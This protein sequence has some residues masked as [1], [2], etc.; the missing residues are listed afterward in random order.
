MGH[1][2]RGARTRTR[3]RAKGARWISTRERVAPRKKGPCED[4]SVAPGGLGAVNKGTVGEERAYL[5]VS[6]LG[7]RCDGVVEAASCRALS[8]WV[9]GLEQGV[10]CRD[11]TAVNLNRAVSY[12]ACLV[13]SGRIQ[14]DSTYV[15]NPEATI[16]LEPRVGRI[17]RH[18]VVHIFE[19]HGIISHT[20]LFILPKRLTY[21]SIT[22][23]SEHAQSPC[24]MAGTFPR[25]FASRSWGGAGRRKGSV[26]QYW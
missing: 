24:R 19:L 11:D 15:I 13:D 14:L 2:R 12:I 7:E 21:S 22:L 3:R 20:V 9:L 17:Q 10:E 4:V 5:F 6:G 1:P 8:C 18:A 26:S 23:L 16:G 25:G